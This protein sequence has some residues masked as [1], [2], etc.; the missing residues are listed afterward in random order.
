MS[1][2]TTSNRLLQALPPDDLEALLPHFER[3]E[4]R[5]GDVLWTVGQPLACA[6]FPEAGLSSNLAVTGGGRRVEVGCF[7]CEGMVSTATVLGSDRAA[8]ELLVQVGGPWLRIGTETLRNA[9][10]DS[11]ALNDLM[12]RYAHV[13]MLTLSQ[14]ALSN[15]AQ[16]IEERLARWILMTHDRIDGDEL[17]LTHEF[18][19]IMLATRRPSVTLAI[20]VIE[21]YGA[22]RAMRGLIVVRDR[23]RLRELAGQSYGPAE[24]EYERLIGPFR[25]QP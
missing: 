9:M 15:G 2:R 11:S 7:G 5:K 3:V 6:Y 16:T 19:S 20:Q 12:L 17:P 18:L 1:P 22:I 8:H 10:R 13:L 14:T 21:G 25:S 24:A 23:A 4:V